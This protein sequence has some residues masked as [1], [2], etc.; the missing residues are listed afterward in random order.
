M[1]RQQLLDSGWT[2]GGKCTTCG[3][4]YDKYFKG[5]LE[6]KYHIKNPVFKLYQHQKQ[7]AFGNVSELENKIQLFS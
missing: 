6:I 7:V 5:N 1:T 4:K 2:Y 3:G